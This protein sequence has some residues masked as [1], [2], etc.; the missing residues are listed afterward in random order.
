MSDEPEAVVDTSEKNP[1]GTEQSEKSSRSKA[2][3]VAAAAASKA[4]A[5]VDA[6]KAA[7][8]KLEKKQEDMILSNKHGMGTFFNFTTH[9]C[10]D[11]KLILKI[12]K[13][14][15]VLSVICV[16]ASFTLQKIGF[17]GLFQ[18]GNDNFPWLKYTTNRNAV[19]SITNYSVVDDISFQTD[20]WLSYHGL[21]QANYVNCS[22]GDVG[23]GQPGEYA[24][25]PQFLC[26]SNQAQWH[27][28]IWGYCAYDV[29]NGTEYSFCW[30]GDDFLKIA[31]NPNT[32]FIHAAYDNIEKCNKAAS[33]LYGM[34]FIGVIF[35][36]FPVLD[37][38]PRWNPETDFGHIKCTQLLI[39][40]ITGFIDGFNIFFYLGTCLVLKDIQ[41]VNSGD[42]GIGFSCLIA[43]YL[44]GIFAL[45]IKM[46]IPAV[47]LRDH[48]AAETAK[49]EA[50]NIEAGS[51]QSSQ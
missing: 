38:I 27:L 46:I 18:F 26:S 30:K 2:T 4:K 14:L 25:L 37:V 9:W 45:I 34:L 47:D 16:V 36:I 39:G 20:Q 29:A 42:I 22:L 6:A 50:S 32:G 8:K 10:Y 12:R 33:A 51:I 19:L 17:L 28:T 15:L 35:S 7:Q 21:P 49:A 1:D 44:L 31:A 41:G 48:R 40:C 5:K 24:T 13:P 43:G 23:L 11:S 3:A